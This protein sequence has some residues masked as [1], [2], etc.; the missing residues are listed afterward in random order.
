MRHVPRAPP[1][2]P[3]IV[4]V[5]L[6]GGCSAGPACAIPTVTEAMMIEAMEPLV[7]DLVE[8]VARAPRPYAEVIEAWRTSC[9]RLTVWEEATERG[10]VACRAQEGGALMV[11]A[12]A[13][14]LAALGRAG[15]VIPA[16]R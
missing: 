10:L 4:A 1:R 16:T 3:A 15:R 2:L 8:S 6:S 14:G 11:L 13:A 5:F 12:T 7:L 9:P